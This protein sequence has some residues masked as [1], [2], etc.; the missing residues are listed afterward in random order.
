MVLPH[1][2]LELNPIQIRNGVANATLLTMESQYRRSYYGDGRFWRT[3]ISLLTGLR[4][5]SSLKLKKRKSV[6]N[7]SIGRLTKN[8]KG[9]AITLSHFLNSELDSFQVGTTRN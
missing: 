4:L 6:G 3:D 8:K 9:T 1:E 5:G 7:Y 2:T